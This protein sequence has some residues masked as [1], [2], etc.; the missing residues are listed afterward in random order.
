ME[1][2]DMERVYRIGDSN[3]FEVLPSGHSAWLLVKAGDLSVIIFESKHEVELPSSYRK[4]EEFVYVLQGHLDYDDGRTARAG[5]AVVNL[6][7]T[8]QSGRYV[9]SLLI[10]RVLPKSVASEW[11]PGSKV[12]RI[13][14]VK[15]FYDAGVMTTRRLWAATENFSICICESQP[16]SSFGGASHPEKEIMYVLQGQLQYEDGR[17]AKEGEA[18]INLP[19][20]PHSV[21][22]EIL[23]RTFEA[24]APADPKILKMLK[25]ML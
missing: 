9:G 6:A 18:V 20:M 1:L 24:K 22:R 25:G 11:Y 13:E 14:D 2:S 3:P 8:S 15:T 4:G 17:V 16:G 19:D 23:T 21:R 7:D 10:I 5:E 12:I